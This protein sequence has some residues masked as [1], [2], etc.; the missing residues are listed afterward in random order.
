MSEQEADISFVNETAGTKRKLSSPAF[1]ETLAEKTLQNGKSLAYGDDDSIADMEARQIIVSVDLHLS[2]SNE[3]YATDSNNNGRDGNVPTSGETLLTVDTSQGG[4]CFAHYDNQN[5]TTLTMSS[6]LIV[7]SM[8]VN[9]IDPLIIAE[10]S[11]GNSDDQGRL[12]RL[13]AG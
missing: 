7:S 6:N 9:T 12:V 3:M 4:P 10:H 8:R 2:A 5:E 1:N 11:V 13:L